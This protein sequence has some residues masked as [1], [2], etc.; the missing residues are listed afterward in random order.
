M[1]SLDFQ[2]YHFINSLALTKR[3]SLII[4]QLPNSPVPTRSIN[5]LDY[6]STA[7]LASINQV[8]QSP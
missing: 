8:N 3:M 5:L 2:S 6:Q 1:P 4:N 7:Q